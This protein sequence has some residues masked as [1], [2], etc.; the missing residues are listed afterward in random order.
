MADEGNTKLPLEGKRY[1]V[2][3]RNEYDQLASVEGALVHLDLNGFVVMT[4]EAA[5]TLI[6]KDRVYSM[7]SLDNAQPAPP[8]N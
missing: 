7:R 1:I 4:V 2:K 5:V 6:P 3:F 8:P